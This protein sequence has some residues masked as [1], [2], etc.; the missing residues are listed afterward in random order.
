MGKSYLGRGG[1][2]HQIPINTSDVV[3]VEISEV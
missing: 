2:E 1:M 3:Y